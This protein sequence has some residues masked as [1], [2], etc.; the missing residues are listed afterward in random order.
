MIL[1]AAATPGATV[2]RSRDCGQHLATN[3]RRLAA[4][5]AGSLAALRITP[6]LFATR[7]RSTSDAEC[8]FGVDYM[9]FMFIATDENGL[10][11]RLTTMSLTVA[12]YFL[13]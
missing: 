5:D 13:K 2:N 1:R 4:R 6:A 7:V 9:P 12:A 8:A 3:T 10:P 11:S